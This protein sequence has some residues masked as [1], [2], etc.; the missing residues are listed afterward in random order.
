MFDGAALTSA[1]YDEGEIEIPTQPALSEETAVLLQELL[2]FYDQLAKHEVDDVGLRRKTADANRRV[3]DIRQRLGQFEK[4]EAAYASAAAIY[5]ELRRKVPDDLSIPAEISRI[6]NEQGNI[7]WLSHRPQ[8]GGERHRQAL[9]LLESLPRPNAESPSLQFEIARTHYLLG[10]SGTPSPSLGRRRR[11]VEANDNSQAEP[12]RKTGRPRAEPELPGSKDGTQREHR[13]LHQAVAV[14]ENLVEDFPDTPVYSQ[15]LASCYRELYGRSAVSPGHEFSEYRTRAIQILE[16]LVGKFPNAPD[17]RHEL[18]RT[19]LQTS[20]L[21]ATDSRPGLREAEDSLRRAVEIADDL[22]AAYPN[23]PDYAA[24][25]AHALC[26]LA[27]VFRRKN[28]PETVERKL[29]EALETQQLLAARF[30]EASP[31]QAWTAVVQESLAKCVAHRGQFEEARRLLDDSIDILDRLLE[32]QP[33]ASYVH[34]LRER[35]CT[36][37][38]DLAS[39]MG[40]R[41]E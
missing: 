41:D 24:S 37:L 10:R 3:G 8:E 15:L 27:E 31:Y 22:V 25:K 9:A 17:Y 6:H 28:Q 35:S 7:L 36:T 20:V 12:G 21:D 19:Y 38:A 18:C 29:H 5:E 13:H 30:P 23:V 4:A 16:Q 1:Y 39:T 26:R 2:S 14:L 33:E 11:G 32:K 40:E 34:K